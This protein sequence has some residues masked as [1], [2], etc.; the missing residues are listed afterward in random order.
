MDT[1]A[2]TALTNYFMKQK[3]ASRSMKHIFLFFGGEISQFKRLLN[4]PSKKKKKKK[5]GREK[6]KA[7][8]VL[9]KPE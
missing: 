6:K 3:R 7:F 1:E 2:P 5:G 8:R 4:Q 9:S